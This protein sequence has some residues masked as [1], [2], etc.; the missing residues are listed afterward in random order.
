MVSVA[1][2]WHTHLGILIDH[3]NARVPPPFWS[4]H[5]RWEAEYE[6]RLASE[7]GAALTSVENKGKSL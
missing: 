3:L 4:T 1:S 7:D 6:K 2:G 5:V